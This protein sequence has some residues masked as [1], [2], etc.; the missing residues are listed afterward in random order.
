MARHRGVP[1]MRP[2]VLAVLPLLLAGLALA[3]PA[4]APR[5]TFPSVRENLDGGVIDWTVWKLEASAA[6]E[7]RVG[8]WKDQRVQ[9][10]DALDRLAP[11]VLS[12][13]P[14]VRLSP[15]STA[16]D[17]MSGGDELALRLAE[18]LG[19]WRVVET[20]YVSS[21]RVEMDATLD[22]QAWL[23]PALV[24][25]ARQGPAPEPTGEHSGVLV[26][27][28]EL[29][30]RPCMVPSLVPP[31]GAPLFDARS[32][33]EEVVRRAPPVIFVPDPAD[34]RAVERAGEKPI[35][36]RAASADSRCEIELSAADATALAGSADFAAL[37]AAGKLVVVV[38]P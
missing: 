22:L 9:E 36:V 34:P 30:F 4:D 20:R 16:G 24:A 27:V 32:L 19:A 17:L 28:R 3:A 1:L 13:A 15:E 35:F 33:S 7:R 12:L 14:Q 37:S 21:G 10:Q 23:R 2:R 25:L 8:A 18:G 5:S 38:D 31:E 6:S 29:G 11:R 26:D